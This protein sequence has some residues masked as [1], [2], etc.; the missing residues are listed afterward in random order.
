MKLAQQSLEYAR[1]Y[2]EQPF[3]KIIDGL[4]RSS[5]VM[6]KIEGAD[7]NTRGY[8]YL[9]SKQK[10]RHPFS[11]W[12]DNGQIVASETQPMKEQYRFNET[13]K[14]VKAVEDWLDREEVPIRR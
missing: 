1:H 12:V 5:T 2:L 4:L 6:A 3:K 9:A 8:L 11:I 10:G 14:L 7:F 13:Q